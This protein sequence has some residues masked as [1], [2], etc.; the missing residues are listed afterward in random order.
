MCCPAVYSYGVV[1]WELYH[2]K[3]AVASRS[4]PTFQ[5]GSPALLEELARSCLNLSPADRPT[6]CGVMLQLCPLI[7]TA[8]RHAR[9]R[10]SR[11]HAAP[12]AH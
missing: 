2:A 10:D 5:R 3:P 12:G 1:L 7:D 9:Q 6:F 11:R 4:F 8:S